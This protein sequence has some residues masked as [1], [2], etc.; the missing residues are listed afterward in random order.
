MKIGMTYDLRDDYLAAGL[1]EEETAE[2]DRPDTIEA[3]EHALN[4]LGYET[5]R[6][7]NIK[8]LARHLVHGD[9]WDMVFN[10][11]EGLKGFGREAQVPALLDAYDIPYTFSDPLA[12]SL[13]LH[14][15][16]AKHVIRDMGL[17]TPDFF[18]VEAESHVVPIDI[19]F[20]LFA[21]PLAEGT[22]KGINASSMIKNRRELVSVC[23]KL[24]D[25]YNQPALV[26]RFLP[27]REFTVGIVGTGK[28]AK[29]I[30]V[31]EV[32]LREDAEPY[33]HSYWNKERCEK[34]VEYRLVNDP[35]GEAAKEVALAAWRGLGCRDGGRID[36]RADESGIP[37]FIEAN[38]LAGLNP[39]HSDLC[40]IAQQAGMA[41]VSLIEEI[42]S[43]ALERCSSGL[44]GLGADKFVTSGVSQSYA[45]YRKRLK[46]LR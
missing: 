1:G 35:V 6:I 36:L 41:Y 3:I 32:I 30:G 9:R 8:N 44:L 24:L 10:I 31:I 33:A 45:F 43:S 46:Q 40:I 2:F 16:M 38:P 25:T 34:L 39:K 4:D 20:P 22:G 42:M 27:G 23:R 11:A 28:D 12:L 15:G 13:T 29:A 5:D 7:G 18:V 21:K 19:G 17:P 14:K 26:E 37:N